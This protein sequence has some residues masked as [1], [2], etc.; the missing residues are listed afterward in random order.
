M[1][2]IVA[3]SAIFML[4]VA[5]VSMFLKKRPSPLPP[6]TQDGVFP[7]PVLPSQAT[8]EKPTFLVG[9]TPP[10]FP[11]ELAM[12]GA[13]PLVPQTEGARVAQVLGLGNAVALPDADPPTWAWSGGGATL[14]VSGDP[15][16]ID[17]AA[18]P[19]S[20]SE[21]DTSKHNYE[22]LARGFL[23]T[24]I[25][26]QQPFS[27]L[28]GAVR[29]YALSGADLVEASSASGASVVEVGYEYAISQTPLFLASP[30]RPGVSVFLYGDGSLLRLRMS[31]PPSVRSIGRAGALAAKDVVLSRLA[32]KEAVVASFTSPGTRWLFDAQEQMPAEASYSKILLGYYYAGGQAQLVPVSVGVALAP[33]ADVASVFVT[34]VSATP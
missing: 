27:L 9:V 6:T 17:F 11:R 10:D 15:V 26:P 25:L 8:E 21:V 28:P 32:G 19:R 3:I 34:I 16:E 13:A 14:A 24:A 7:S 18:A 12:Y 22:E 33:G 4:V 31:L 2:K 20:P 23:S 30:A 29:F 1:K 5:A